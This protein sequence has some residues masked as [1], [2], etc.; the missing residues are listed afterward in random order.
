M[1]Y[2][3]RF[4]LC[5]LIS[6]FTTEAVAILEALKYVR[7][8]KLRKL[9]ICQIAIVLKVLQEYNNLKLSLVEVTFY[10]VK[11]YSGI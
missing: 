5:S 8:N 10:W 1:N 6:I 9:A 7:D 2:K 4:R 3:K 11:G